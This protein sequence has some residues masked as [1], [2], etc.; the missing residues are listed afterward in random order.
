MNFT[1]ETKLQEFRDYVSEESKLYLNYSKEI[2]QQNQIEKLN[3]INAA[4]MGL[5]ASINE[6]KFI[7]ANNTQSVNLQKW[8]DAI[9]I[10]EITLKE[11]ISYDEIIKVNKDINGLIELKVEVDEA[12]VLLNETKN[13]LKNYLQENLTTD[14]APLILDQIKIIDESINNE[15]IREITDTT[16]KSKEFILKKIIEPEKLKKAEEIENER[17]K[18][19]EEQNKEFE[20]IFDK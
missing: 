17:K 9:K 18:L 12:I 19:A 7:M 16:E 6:L 11:L 20:E 15:N 5:D 2:S 4:I 8:T 14:L 10:A 1:N 3:T 13:E